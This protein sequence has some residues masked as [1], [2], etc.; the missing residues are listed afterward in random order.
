MPQLLLLLLRPPVVEEQLTTAII[1]PEMSSVPW[2]TLISIFT[3]P[4]LNQI[5]SRTAQLN[6]SFPQRPPRMNNESVLHPFQRSSR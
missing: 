1:M 5:L 4:K 6:Y 2:P 3:N